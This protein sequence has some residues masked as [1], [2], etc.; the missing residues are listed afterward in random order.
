MKRTCER[1]R[2]SDELTALPPRTHLMQRCNIDVFR[3]RHRPP[4]VSCS[5]TEHVQQRQQGGAQGAAIRRLSSDSRAARVVIVMRRLGCSARRSRRSSSAARFAEPCRIR[6]GAVVAGADVTDRQHRHQREARRHD[7][8]RRPLRRA[9]AEAGHLQ[10]HGHQDRLQERG[11]RR[12]QARRAADARRRCDA[13]ARA[14]HRAGHGPRPHGA[15][16]ET[17]QLHR[18]PDDREQAPG[19]SAAQRPQSVLTGHARAGRGARAGLVAVHQRRPQRHERSHD[20]RRLER[21]RREQ[22]VDP[23]LELHAV[24]R[25]GAGVQR[26]DQLGERRVRPARRRRHQPGHQERHQHLSRD[27]LRVRP[28]QQARRDQLL[29]QPRGTE[30][31][32]LQAQPVR[33]QRRR[34]GHAARLQRRRPDVLLRQLRRPAAGIGAR[35]R[36]FTVPLPEWRT[37]DFS[38]LRNASGQPII[39][40]DPATTRPDPDNP[41]LVH[42]RRRSPAI[43]F[44]PNRIS[45]VGRALAQYWPLPNTTPTNAFTQASNYIAVRRAA[46]RRRPHRLARRPRDQRQVADVR[47]LLVVGRSQ[48]GVQQ[49]PERGQLVGRRRPDL[50]DDAQ[51][52]D[53]QQLRRHPVVPG[54]RA[55]R[56]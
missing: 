53:R 11:H 4:A 20:R 15:P 21:Q 46:E 54:Q 48:P 43:A 40:Y 56:T 22:R 16:I 26:A 10:D 8:R 34:P 25:R 9:A 24:G 37:G 14:G 27:R 52:L 39:I 3:C 2:S 6:R 47:A 35:S 13:R 49:L 29:H 12:G 42:P 18:Q 17:T 50:H 51:P 5:K 31:G 28:Q 33:R 44:P 23:R 32:Q 7:R 19:R 45:A 41:G 55:L 38:N 36:R 1:Y 30:Q